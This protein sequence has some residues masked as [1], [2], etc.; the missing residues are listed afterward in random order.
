MRFLHQGTTPSGKKFWKFKTPKDVYEAGLLPSSKTWSD[1]RSARYEAQRMA[2]VVDKFRSGQALPK[3]IHK[4]TPLHAILSWYFD[5]EGTRG[6]LE[7]Y[8][9]VL[10][11][12][13]GS[14]KVGSLDK[15]ILKDAYDKIY[16]EESKTAANVS[17]QLLRRVLDYCVSN[18]IIPFNPAKEFKKNR[19]AENV[20]ILDN[21]WTYEL[22]TSF[23]DKCLSD[24]YTAN[25]GVL[26]ILMAATLQK[27]DRLTY[28]TWSDV[29]FDRGTL[30]IDDIVFELSDN[31]LELLQK[32]Y[33]RFKYQKW[34]VPKVRK[35]Q[36]VLSPYPNVE[37]AHR[38]LILRFGFDTKLTLHSYWI[39]C[40]KQK[41]ADGFPLH[42]LLRIVDLP[43]RTL[44]VM[45]KHD[46][47]TP[48]KA[49]I[50]R[51]PTG[52]KYE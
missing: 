40:I 34:V 50:A 46:L 33:D 26:M 1:G 47:T 8:S 15:V 30:T 9:N 42:L 31:L 22:A 43:L 5:R 52:E 18:S 36:P 29:D 38:N 20:R 41:V 27:S 6:S 11:K 49:D 24:I 28:L 16:K 32:Q 17:L 7:H 35:D 4:D 51:F 44:S 12:Y 2:Q 25:W 21:P 48:I 23:V 10:K 14:R 37:T 3:E 19:T 13:I 39:F 45:Y